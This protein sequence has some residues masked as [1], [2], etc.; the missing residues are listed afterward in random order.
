MTWL[1][2]VVCHNGRAQQIGNLIV[3]HDCGSKFRLVKIKDKIK[4]GVKKKDA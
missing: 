4:E 1:V 2:C 3:C